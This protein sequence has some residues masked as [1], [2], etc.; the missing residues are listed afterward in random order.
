MKV[1]R[2]MGSGSAKGKTLEFLRVIIFTTGNV[3][4]FPVTLFRWKT[5]FLLDNFLQTWVCVRSCA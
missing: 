1:S 2:K 4:R 5:I 3:A